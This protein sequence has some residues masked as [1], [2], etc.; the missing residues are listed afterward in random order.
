ME[1]I[2]RRSLI[3]GTAAAVAALRLRNAGL[4]AALGRQARALVDDPF[5]LGVATGDPSADGFVIW[6]R[7]APDPT[8]GGGMAP[9]PV[10]VGWEVAADAGFAQVVRSGSVVTTA[11][12]A[13][14]VHVVVDGLE[15]DNEWWVRFTADT[16]TSPVGRGRTLPAGGTPP[17]RFAFASCQSYT[18]GYYTA[19]RHL[20]GS[21]C[22][23][24]LHLGDY[25][26]EGG[27]TG[28]VRSH[29]SGECLTLA[30]YRNRYALYK[31]DA[32]LQAAHAA[33]PV[34]P[35]WDDHEIDNDYAGDT[36]ENGASG[37]PFQDRRAAG[38]RAWF[39]HQPV[40]LTAPT[41]PDLQIY[42]SF[43]WGDLAAFHMLDG[44]QYRDPQPCGDDLLSDCPERTTVDRTMLGAD[45]RSWLLSGL[46]SSTAIWDIV[47]QQTV[48]TPLPFAGLY[49]TDQWDGYPQDRQRVWDVLR[50]RPNP[51]VCTGDIHAAGAARMHHDLEDVATERIGTELVG[52]SVSS[53][54]ADAAL[55]DAAETLAR[56]LPYV[57]Y[58]NARQRGYALV[59]LTAESLRAEFRV[60][61]DATVPNGT[62][63]VDHVIEVA[64]RSGAAP[65]PTAP[66]AQPVPADARFTG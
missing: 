42:R 46:S 40:R 60:V 5:T 34:I 61:N 48:F 54:F 49:N 63:S 4:P 23:L 53:G 12:L 6:T 8:N 22:D 25:I 1:P 27:G 20:A 18:S 15:P 13:H 58:V 19:L 32:D 21:G 56:G 37:G 50:Q 10:T 57:E 47:G 28:P 3:V 38:Y 43:S 29:G 17:L 55:V 66:P 45:Q 24:W 51:V 7:L 36:D 26:Y 14:T 9:D 65:A 52:T 64:A 62:V 41:G 44:R 16:F 35:V 33:A 11:D 30:D 2:G 31:T 39:E 59:D